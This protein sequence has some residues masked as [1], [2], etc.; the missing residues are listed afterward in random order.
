MRTFAKSRLLSLAL[1]AGLSLAPAANQAEDI[2]L[3]VGAVPGASYN[4]NVLIVIDNSANWARQAQHWPGGV[5]QGQSEVRAIKNTIAG[6]NDKINV[7]L[8]EHPT[9]VQ[10]MDAGWIRQAVV[11]MSPGNITAFNT[12]LDTIFNNITSTNEKTNGNIGYGG[13][14][15]DAFKYF[16][17]YT[18]PAHATDNIAGTPVDRLHF[19]P[20][21]YALPN[22]IPTWL[23]DP[24]GYNTQW[25]QFK[26]PITADNN[27][28]KN[29]VVFIANN[30]QGNLPPDDPTLLTNVGCSTGRIARPN[31]TQST[32]TI[33]TSIGNTAACYTSATTCTSKVG[34]VEFPTECGPNNN[35][36]ESC[37]C[38]TPVVEGSSCPANSAYY[39]VLGVRAPGKYDMGYT[40]ACYNN[41]NTCSTADYA[42]QCATYDGGCV[43][44]GTRSITTGCTSNKKKY[45]VVATQISSAS[46]NLGY[47]SQCY[48]DQAACSTA[49]YAALCTNFSSC[50]CGA[51]TTTSKT[52]SVGSSRYTVEGRF[53]MLTA[54]PTG[55]YTTPSDSTYADNWARCLFQTDVS[56]VT[57][58]QN[59]RTYVID[60][61]KDQQ[62]AAFTS[63]LM[64]MAT[65]GGGKYY[66]A[67]NEQAIIDALKEIFTEIQGVN[68]TFASASL[69]VN[70]TNRSQNENQVFIG[71]F[72]PD[73]D[74]KPRWFGNM[75]RYQLIRAADGIGIDLGDAFSNAAVSNTTG[76][77]QDC[78]TSF[79]TSDSGAYWQN[80]AVNPPPIG[81]CTTD[82][83]S[84]YSDAPD[85]PQVE[86]G[87][88]AEV[89][90]KGNNPPATNTTPTW[91]V[92]RTVYTGNMAAFTTASTGLSADIV[93]FT[94]GHDVKDER[95]NTN[96]TE[97]RPSIH[98]DVVHSRPLPI[99]YGGTTGV[100][101]YYG[102]NEGTL[103]S[104]NAETG[105][106]RWAYIAPEHY[107]KLQ[108]L[109]DNVPLVNYPNT[110][111]TPPVP[112]PLPKGYFFD[113]SIGLYQTFNSDSTSDK[114]WIFPAMRRGGRM[115]YAFDVSSPDAPSLKWKIGCPENFTLSDDPATTDVYERSVS[116]AGCTA[117]TSAIGQTWSLPAVA[118][119]KGYPGSSA[120]PTPIIVMG[121][122]YDPCEDANSSAPA[123]AGRKGNRIFILD[124]GNGT[125]LRTFD[126]TSSVASDVAM[127]DIDY[128]G[129][130]DYAYAVDLGGN[131]YRVSFIDTNKTALDKDHWVSA[132]VAYTNGAGRKFFYPP[133]LLPASDKIYLALGSGDREHPLQTQYPWNNV[134]NRFYVYLDDPALSDALNLDTA[135]DYTVETTCATDKLLPGS[136]M[137]AWFMDLTCPDVQSGVSCP[138]NPSGCGEQTVT[139]ALILGGMAVFSTNS[140]V[141]PLAGACSNALGCARGYWV[142][143]FNASGAVGVTGSCG[144]S[145]AA[146]LTGGGLP[147]SPVFGTV[148]VDGA[149]VPVCIGCANKAGDPSPAIDPSLVNPTISWKRKMQYWKSSGD[150]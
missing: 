42:A 2:D 109:F 4:P 50:V 8:L 128:D 17:G 32:T 73:P 135:T 107:T 130:V 131:I 103:R 136:A 16:G 141:E 86:K 3:F 70:A 60:V 95:A 28:G 78:A 31:L 43:C 111:L 143:L 57:G 22:H 127:V 147:P 37:A 34:T 105:K 74:A 38:T 35:S 29:F 27:C 137:R 67:T 66:A 58:Q 146:E 101:V 55:T 118:K 26:S 1:C 115:V 10:A 13:M 88:V 114:A 138:A 134:V 76:F 63:M 77:V 25:T 140:P 122:G 96:Q 133:A 18:S 9:Q 64:S 97:T 40:S 71:M 68:S 144:G 149:L 125:I 117:G 91:A 52:C 106:E 145:R 19:G 14:L 6:L 39:S 90:R 45:M 80:V 126:T 139:S 94:L 44:D 84:D 33:A 150:N 47:T 123:C 48:A 30:A 102:A 15:F 21:A 113:G 5:Q 83:F 62:N 121:G 41:A 75:K 89:L 72:R 132:K 24:N 11:P 79:W 93:N 112:A 49:D 110:F 108:R 148:P 23:A 54:T 81:K 142:N 65:Q 61:Y 99:N 53:D 119:V 98:G 100:T 92:N 120:A 104:V 12:R 85:G 124:A 116:D 82:I 56:A 20:D 36:Y 7:G 87:A 46:T 51:P 59:V 69:P 129:Y